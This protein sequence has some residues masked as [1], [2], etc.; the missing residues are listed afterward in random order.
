MNPNIA[1]TMWLAAAIALYAAAV[2]LSRLLRAAAAI[3]ASVLA[4]SYLLNPQQPWAFA[5]QIWRAAQGPLLQLVQIGFA[6][7]QRLWGALLSVIAN[8]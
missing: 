7:G 2:A 1:V 6:V 4:V 8:R 3:A 5:E